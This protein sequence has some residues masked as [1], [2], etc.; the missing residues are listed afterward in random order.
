MIPKKIHYCWFGRGDK[1]EDIK[2]YIATW[3]A[4][5]PDYEIIE[6]N[7]D[8]FDIDIC[9]YTRQAYEAQKYAF[10]SD[11]AR[12][13]IL[14]HVGGIYFDTDIEV[15]RNF[16][17]ILENRKMILGFE[18]EHY[19]MTAFIAAEPQMQCFEKLLYQ[20]NCKKF[21]LDDGKYDTL[22]N[23]VIVTETMKK[24]GLVPDGKRQ[25]FADKCEIY[26]REYFSAFN[27]TMNWVEKTDNTCLVH[28]C[29]GTWQT[30]R[31]KI[32]PFIKRILVSAFGEKIFEKIKSKVLKK[33][34]GG[35]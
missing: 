21:I 17:S 30:P 8:N 7:E 24:F 14:Y 35:R 3:K 32:K 1:P 27:I 4:F 9:K 20:Y 2:K 10:V 28:H 6:W 26:P 29:M 23:P 12:L 34:A 33:R 11:Y 25:M 19:V 15:C 5:F 13:Y 22:P 31:D 16:E 18:D